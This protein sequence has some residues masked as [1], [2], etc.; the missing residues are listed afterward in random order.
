MDRTEEY[1]R[2]LIAP[3][4]DAGTK[5]STLVAALFDRDGKLVSHWS[6][7][8]QELERFTVVGA[9]PAEP[10]LYRLRVAAIDSTGRAGTADYEFE[11]E[12]VRTGP[13]RLSSIILGLSR[14]GSF[15]P[16][17]R[18]TDEPVAIAYFEMDGAVGPV[19]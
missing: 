2:D 9:L 7:T 8:A 3:F 5:L 11:A 4:V 19:L 12:T 17:L 16:R 10:G 13:L 15:Q 6:A 18:F 14:D 1:V